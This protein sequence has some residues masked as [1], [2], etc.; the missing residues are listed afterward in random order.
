MTKLY[1]FNKLG[2][3][4]LKGFPVKP[5]TVNRDV[6]NLRAMLN[7]ADEHAKIDSNP[8]GRIK[9]LDENNVLESLLSQY[10]FESL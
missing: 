4:K 3:S 10:Q 6:T 9:L 1:L 8:I 7:N 2:I 5:S